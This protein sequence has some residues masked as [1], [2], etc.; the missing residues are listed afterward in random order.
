VQLGDN[1]PT[2]DTIAAQLQSDSCALRHDLKLHGGFRRKALVLYR[3]VD[4]NCFI[5]DSAYYKGAKKGIMKFV[6]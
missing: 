2:V 4:T 1:K 6:N 3:G 5:V